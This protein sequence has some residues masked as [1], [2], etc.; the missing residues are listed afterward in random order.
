MIVI[1]NYAQL[2]IGSGTTI[3]FIYH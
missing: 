1:L 3:Y 2:N